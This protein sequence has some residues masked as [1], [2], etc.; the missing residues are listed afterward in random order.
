MRYSWVFT[1]TVAPPQDSDLDRPTYHYVRLSKDFSNH[2]KIYC[3]HRHVKNRRIFCFLIFNVT[4]SYSI[5]VMNVI[6]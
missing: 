2:I 6:K 1:I 5:L 4:L 3:L